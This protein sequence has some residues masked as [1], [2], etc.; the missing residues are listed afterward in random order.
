MFKI[1]VYHVREVERPLFAK[2]NQ[3]NYDINLVGDRLTPATISKAADSDAVLLTAG[4]DAD[5]KKS[6]RSCMIM[7]LSMCLP[8]LLELITLI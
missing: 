5:E 3:N 4:D 8:E 6:L 2:L 1:T 7:G